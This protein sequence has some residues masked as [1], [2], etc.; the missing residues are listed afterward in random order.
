MGGKFQTTTTSMVMIFV[1][2][3]YLNAFVTAFKKLLI[4]IFEIANSKLKQN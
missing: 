2:N 1:T 4:G 3:L